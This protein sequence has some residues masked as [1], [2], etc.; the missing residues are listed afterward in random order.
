MTAFLQ[1]NTMYLVIGAVVT[2]LTHYSLNRKFPVPGAAFIA[3]ANTLNM[4]ATIIIKHYSHEKASE[5][6]K[7]Y[8]YVDTDGN[9][10]NFIFTRL[11]TIFSISL[12]LLFPIFARYVGQR[13]GFQV[14][15]YLQTLAYFILSADAVGLAKNILDIGCDVYNLKTA[16]T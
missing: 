10:T 14:P 6:T 2:P 7:D 12:R 13:M 5:L 1:G 9:T 11:N 4:C 15:G 8:G 16:T 3:I